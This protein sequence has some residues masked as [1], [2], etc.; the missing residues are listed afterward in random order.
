MNEIF[1][2]KTEQLQKNL[3]TLNDRLAQVILQP[4]DDKIR[5]LVD[6]RRLC[7][8]QLQSEGI[9]DNQAEQNTST[10]QITNLEI[11]N[12]ISAWCSRVKTASKNQVSFEDET[13]CN[14]F[15]DYALPKIWHFINDIVVVI[16]PPSTK[17]LDVL[18]QRNQKNIVVYVDTEG[19]QTTLE[20]LTM[21]EGV[22]LCKSISDLE[23]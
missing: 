22:H 4:N 13:F 21:I 18:K 3:A 12:F 20:N 9:S 17:I 7:L 6:S 1:N 14:Q 19:P 5:S 11:N 23:R 2:P 15:L 10:S 8:A 16:S